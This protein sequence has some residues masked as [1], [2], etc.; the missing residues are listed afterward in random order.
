MLI[1]HDNVWTKFSRQTLYSNI[2]TYSSTRPIPIILYLWRALWG[3]RHIRIYPGKCLWAQVNNIEIMEVP[4]EV[5]KGYP[6]EKM[7]V[8]AVPYLVYLM[9]KHWM[10]S[11]SCI[12]SNVKCPKLV[13]IERNLCWFLFW[14]M[15]AVWP[16]YQTCAQS[17]TELTSCLLSYKDNHLCT[18]VKES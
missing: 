11:V 4:Q 3:S 13:S 1:L 15:A 10:F 18:K 5:I 6:A 12:S 14:L 2:K 8:S 17:I 9:S 7:S 16:K